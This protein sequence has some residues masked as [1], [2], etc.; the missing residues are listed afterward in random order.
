MKLPSKD[1]PFYLGLAVL[2][3]LSRLA[4][5]VAGVR[6][7]ATPLA[8]A[9]QLLDPH[10][11]E[12]DLLRSLFYL[13]AQPPLFNAFVGF[14]LKLTPGSPEPF[15]QGLYHLA[16]LVVLW[17]EFFLLRQL[18]VGP[19]LAAAAAG[20]L[21]VQPAFILY[22]SWLTYDLP[23]T[24]MLVLAATALTQLSKAENTQHGSVAFLALLTTVCLTRSLFHPLYFVTICGVLTWQLSRWQGQLKLGQRFLASALVALALVLSVPVKNLVLFSTPATSSWLGM[25]LW[26]IAST[27]LTPEAAAALQAEG[28]LSQ[29]ATIKA[30]SPLPDYSGVL[31]VLPQYPDVPAVAAPKD[32]AGGNNYNHEA[33]IAIAALYQED[34]LWILRNRPKDYVLGVA[35]AVYYYLTP[36]SLIL[37]VEENR[38]TFG[39]YA[40]VV[41]GFLYG[42]LPGVVSYGANDRPIFLFSTL[43]IPLLLVAGLWLAYRHRQDPGLGPALAFM[44][45]TALY[46]AVV[47]NTLEVLENSRFRFYTDPFLVAFAALALRDA[48]RRLSR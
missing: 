2:F 9:W 12:T 35:K 45:L 32:S 17:A 8:T 37:Q 31:Q 18:G 42:R 11:L 23:V 10:L 30:F 29:A 19:R 39:A 47:G 6:F 16:G 7:D 43:G 26:R 25:N 44:A 20:L 1:R 46:V 22:E 27:E 3:V 38:R 5:W 15:F 41:E 36:P 21:V 48:L 4:A 24:A 40:N 34:A 13:H 28:K 14:V 33:Y